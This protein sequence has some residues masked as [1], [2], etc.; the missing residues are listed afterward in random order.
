MLQCVRLAVVGIDQDDALASRKQG[1]VGQAV[2]VGD[3]VGWG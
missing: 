1:C 2:A 3:G